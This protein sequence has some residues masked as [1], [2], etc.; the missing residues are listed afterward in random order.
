M[1]NFISINEGIYNTD[2]NLLPLIIL[3]GVI[4]LRTLKLLRII[5]SGL[6]GIL[7]YFF[8][9]GLFLGIRSI[10][11]ITIVLFVIGNIMVMTNKP[12]PQRAMQTK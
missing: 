3:W 2:R 4:L 8:W 5:R 10:L 1:K 7:T 12:P 9:E 11:V 6:V